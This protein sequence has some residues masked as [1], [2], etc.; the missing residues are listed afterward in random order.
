MNKFD[1]IFK[2]EFGEY[3]LEQA[4]KLPDKESLEET[5]STLA[6]FGLGK[7]LE[8]IIKPLE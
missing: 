2:C 6:E 1:L 7:T 5:M 3:K 8:I 4:K